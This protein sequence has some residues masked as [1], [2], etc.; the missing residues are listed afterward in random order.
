MVDQGTRPFGQIDMPH[1]LVLRVGFRADVALADQLLHR[2]R[3]RTL[4]KAAKAGKVLHADPVILKNAEQEKLLPAA[5][6]VL[7]EHEV[8]IAARVAL[9]QG[10]IAEN[11]D[12][13]VLH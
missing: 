2:A 5:D 6:L 3:Y 11:G 13:L 4:V 8:K 12:G 10:N 9:Q 1:T 7:F